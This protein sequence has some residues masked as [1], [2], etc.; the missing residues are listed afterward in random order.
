MEVFSMEKMRVAW[1]RKGLSYGREMVLNLKSSGF[2][3][4]SLV[5]NNA[6]GGI[7]QIIWQWLFWLKNV[8]CSNTRK[9]LM[10]KFTRKKNQMLTHCARIIA[11]C[12]I[13]AKVFLMM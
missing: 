5:P 11:S 6:L 10:M 3:F 4:V 7:Y 1:R 8:A 13:V 2:S 12:F 9:K